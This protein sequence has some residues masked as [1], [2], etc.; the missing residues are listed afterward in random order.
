MGAES[1][2]TKVHHERKKYFSKEEYHRLL[3]H[4]RKLAKDGE[5][6]PVTMLEVISSRCKNDVFLWSKPKIM[7]VFRHD[8]ICVSKC[9]DEICKSDFSNDKTDRSGLVVFWVIL[10]SKRCSWY[11]HHNSDK[12]VT[13]KWILIFVVFH[14]L[15][16]AKSVSMSVSLKLY[17]L[18]SN[19]DSSLSAQCSLR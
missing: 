2:S 17:E 19:P 4:I 14:I 15:I 10:W 12:D 7:N 18:C 13:S 11:M 1:S 9:W 8:E 6:V 16:S 3:H 5:T